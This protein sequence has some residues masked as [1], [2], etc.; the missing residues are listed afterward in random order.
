MFPR[1]LN[2][3][4]PNIGLLS[5]ELNQTISIMLFKLDAANVEKV[6][7]N[8]TDTILIALHMGKA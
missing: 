8:P 5:D 7:C 4:G 2:K 6:N 1:C 3:L